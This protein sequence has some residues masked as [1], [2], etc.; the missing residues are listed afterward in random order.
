MPDTKSMSGEEAATADLAWLDRR[1]KGWHA[2]RS[3]VGGWYASRLGCT[4]PRSAIEAGLAMTLGG[5]AGAQQLDDLLCKQERIAERL[6][7][8]RAAGGPV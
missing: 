2:W 6:A 1:H 3:N 4:L 7:D 5:E 8:V